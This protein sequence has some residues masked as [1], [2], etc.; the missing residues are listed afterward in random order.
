MIGIYT[1]INKK[2]SK[3]YIGSSICI[4]SR[5]NGHINL[6]KRNAHENEHLQNA[7]NKYGIENFEFEPL[8][9]CTLDTLQSEE[10][11]WMNLTN[12]TNRLYGYNK[13][14][15]AYNSGHKISNETREKIKIK[16][17]GRI[18]NRDGVE[19]TRLK[20]L[21]QIRPIQSEKML[22]RWDKTKMYFGINNLSEEN[23]NKLKEKLRLITKK[24]FEKDENISDSFKSVYL[25]CITK[26]NVLYFR[27]LHLAS[28]HF[29]VDRG[30]IKYTI[31]NKNGYFKKIDCT[32]VKIT[33]E[34]Y[35]KNKTSGEK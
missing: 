31:N 9:E 13:N 6:L 20:N 4:K 5:L 26:D 17:T 21:G 16:A 27:S 12:C 3:I 2:D 10:Q 25:K 1:I 29:K 35:L 23:L 7:V 33:K 32:F 30:G 22:Q 28:K 24:R 34:E 14:I 15:L 18:A 19:K 11:L 8:I